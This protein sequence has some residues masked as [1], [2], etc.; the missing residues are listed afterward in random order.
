MTCAE[1]LVKF[2]FQPC[3]R[4]AERSQFTGY[5]LAMARSSGEQSAGSGSVGWI[6]LQQ[7]AGCKHGEIQLASVT[8]PHV[9]YVLSRIV[10]AAESGDDFVFQ[11]FESLYRIGAGIRQGFNFNLCGFPLRP[12]RPLL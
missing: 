12:Q 6:F 11:L 10:M 3:S 2:F 5:A 9:N 1:S 7:V 4:A 8:T